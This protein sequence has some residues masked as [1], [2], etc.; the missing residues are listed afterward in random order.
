MKFEATKAWA[1]F[2]STHLGRIEPKRRE[3]AMVDQRLS[4]IFARTKLCVP[5]LPRKP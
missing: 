2:L 3:S 4:A 1:G 5:L